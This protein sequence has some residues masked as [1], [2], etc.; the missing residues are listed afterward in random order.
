MFTKTGPGGSKIFG[1]GRRRYEN[2]WALVWSFY[3]KKVPFLGS[4]NEQKPRF[5]NPGPNVHRNRSGKILGTGCAGIRCAGI[6]LGHIPTPG[7]AP[8]NTGICPGAGKWGPGA[9]KWV[10]GPGKWAPWGPQGPQRAGKWAPWGP[11]GPQ[12]DGAE[13]VVIIG[14]VGA[15]GVVIIGRVEAGGVVINAEV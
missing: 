12:R 13:G 3:D 2:C 8:V 1:G 9:G 14:R 15:G 10:R 7:M 5:S 6:A 4:K 11:Q